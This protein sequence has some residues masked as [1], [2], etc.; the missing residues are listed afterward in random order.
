MRYV[1]LSIFALFYVKWQAKIVCLFCNCVVSFA[2]WSPVSGCEP[3]WPF[4]ACERLCLWEVCEVFTWFLHQQGMKPCETS[5]LGG[6]SNNRTHLDKR[7]FIKN[8]RSPAD[9]IKKLQSC[10]KQNG[11]A[12]CEAA[13]RANL[14]DVEYFYARY[15]RSGNTHS[16]T[17]FI[18]DSWWFMDSWLRLITDLQRQTFC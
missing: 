4:G 14:F 6:N 10:C 7:V 1:F 13:V 11:G 2:K 9:K 3:E 17:S 15:F 5:A 18:L 12:Y 16:T 8:W